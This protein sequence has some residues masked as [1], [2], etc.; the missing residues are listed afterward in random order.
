VQE[1]NLTEPFKKKDK[2]LCNKDYQLSDVSS[3]NTVMHTVE[4]KQKENSDDSCLEL[5]S[6]PKTAIKFLLDWKKYVSSDF[7]YRYLKVSNCLFIL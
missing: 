2:T 4:I 7:R 3:T 6:V 5:P 1:A